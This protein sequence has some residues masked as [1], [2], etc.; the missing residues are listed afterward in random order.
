MIGTSDYKASVKE[1]QTVSQ[2]S[3]FYSPVIDVCCIIVE[4]LLLL[5]SI[6]KLKPGDV[7]KLAQCRTV[8]VHYKSLLLKQLDFFNVKVCKVL[9][10]I[11]KLKNSFSII[12]TTTAVYKAND[13]S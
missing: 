1:D 8:K 9:P 10:I 2:T 4:L 11:P 5:Y 13:I 12:K 6:F 7:A 3:S